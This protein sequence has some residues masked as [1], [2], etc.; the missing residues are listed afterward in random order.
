MVPF[1]KWFLSGAA[2]VAPDHHALDKQI[3]SGFVFLIL[4]EAALKDFE[5]TTKEEVTL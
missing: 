4:I 2:N 3:R 1:L 5:A